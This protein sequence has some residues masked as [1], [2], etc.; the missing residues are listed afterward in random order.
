MIVLHFRMQGENHSQ[1]THGK[2]RLCTLNQI[3]NHHVR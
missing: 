3:V 1:R 2:C